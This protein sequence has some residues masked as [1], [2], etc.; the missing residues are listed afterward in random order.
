MD[1]FEDAVWR[2]DRLLPL[3]AHF[4][5]AFLDRYV[6]GET[7][8]DAYLNGLTVQSDAG[9]WPGAPVGRVAQYSPGPPA[10]TVWK[11][12]QPGRAVGMSFEYR[13][14]PGWR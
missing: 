4:I 9:R 13:P 14:A 12:F 11:G 6:K 8:R 3:Q 10:S 5:T 1:W 7:G 2:K